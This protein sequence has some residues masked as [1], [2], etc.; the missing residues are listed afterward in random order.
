M[1]VFSSIAATLSA[2]AGI[3]GTAASFVGAMQQQKGAKKAE[4]IRK[5]QMDLQA[6]RDRRA[7]LRQ[8]I[9]AR[10][11]ASSNAT[12]QGADQGSGLAGGLS[13]I[14]NQ[15]AQNQLGIN[16]GQELGTRMF[17]AQS[18]IS[19]GQTLQSIGGAI[20]GFGDFFSSSFEQGSRVAQSY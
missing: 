17:G 11:Q 19:K 20:S 1:A 4:E 14:S 9:I 2:V 15:N 12:A 7:S 8:S 10:A 16:Q 5:K 13:G 18:Q 6:Q 3:A